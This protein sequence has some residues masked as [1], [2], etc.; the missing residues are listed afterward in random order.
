[1]YLRPTSVAVHVDMNL[2]PAHVLIENKQEP[3]VAGRVSEIICQTS[4]SRPPAQVTWYLGDR[5]IEGGPGSV[6]KKCFPFGGLHRV[7]SALCIAVGFSWWKGGAAEW[8]K[9]E[10]WR[11]PH[12]S[13]NAENT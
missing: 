6:R 10:E 11:I 7:L 8:Q 12:Q 2:A 5:R 1:M 13:A 4:G 9:E 3:L